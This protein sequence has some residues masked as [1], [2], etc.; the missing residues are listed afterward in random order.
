MGDNP[1]HFPDCGGDCP[2]ERVSLEMVSI[3]IQRLNQLDALRSYRLP[4]EAEWEYACRAGSRSAFANGDIKELDCGQD[5]NL[6]QLGWYCGNADNTT[7]PVAKKLPN[8]WGL[9]D[10]HG[11]VFEWTGDWYGNYPFEPVTDPAGPVTGRGWV[12]RGGCWKSFARFCR[13]ANRSRYSP[14][15]HNRYTGFR[16]VVNQ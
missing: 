9:Y 10:M 15:F 1:S 6:D 3:F 16:L 14:D 8:A 4:T 13:S 7:H 5:P 2:V 11:N 12:I